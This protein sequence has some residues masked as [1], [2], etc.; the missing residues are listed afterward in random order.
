MSNSNKPI[1]KPKEAY[2]IDNYI[3]SFYW[4][5]LFLV[6]IFSSVWDSYLCVICVI[7]G[8]SVQ[9][10]KQEVNSLIFR[11]VTWCKQYKTLPWICTSPLDINRWLGSALNDK[12]HGRWRSWYSGLRL[13]LDIHTMSRVPK[14]HV[15]NHGATSDIVRM[16]TWMIGSKQTDSCQDIYEFVVKV[17]SISFVRHNVTVDKRDL[18]RQSS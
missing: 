13:R 1:F 6:F 10:D 7:I 5:L 11:M 4:L 17:L 8:F 16:E 18:P 15:A 9:D 14:P 12:K 2:D 3:L